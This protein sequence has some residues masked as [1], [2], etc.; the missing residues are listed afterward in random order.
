[1][2]LTLWK[3][4][5]DGE[6]VADS[7]RQDDHRKAGDGEPDASMALSSDAAESTALAILHQ[8]R[9]SRSLSLQIPTGI[10]TRQPA[11]GA[12]I[13]TMTV[14]FIATTSAT[15]S[16]SAPASAV[17]RRS[18]SSWPTTPKSKSSGP[19]W[20]RRHT[21][22]SRTRGFFEI[23]Y[24]L[25]VPPACI[26]VGNGRTIGKKE[27]GRAPSQPRHIDHLLMPAGFTPAFTGRDA[28]E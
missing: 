26:R 27:Q 9:A 4:D 2:A 10:I 17:A 21:P 13:Q 23:S 1:M 24:L 22:T 15:L 14:G 6:R 20:K 8:F 3:C 7:D 28:V 19:L 18:A 11:V 5:R 16:G 25:A 12:T